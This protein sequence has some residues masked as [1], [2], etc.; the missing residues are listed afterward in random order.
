MTKKRNYIGVSQ[1]ENG[2]WKFT[3]RKANG[4]MKIGTGY[5]TAKVAAL[6]RDEYILK[7]GLDEKSNFPVKRMAKMR[8]DAY[9]Q[10]FGSLK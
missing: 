5:S 8:N 3:V 2:S 4:K 9:E 10:M 6:M 1:D 7:H